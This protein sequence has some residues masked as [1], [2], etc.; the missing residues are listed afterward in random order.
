MMQ[1]V[2][3]GVIEPFCASVLRAPTPSAFF[4][5]IPSAFF[6]AIF[7]AVTRK[8]PHAPMSFIQMRPQSLPRIVCFV[9]YPW[10]ILEPLANYVSTTSHCRYDDDMIQPRT[11]R[12]QDIARHEPGHAQPQSELDLNI[13]TLV[14]D[15]RR[16]FQKGITRPLIW[17]RRQLAALS[18]MLIAEREPLEQALFADLHKSPTE[19]QITELG[20]LRSEISYTLRHLS[21]WAH[22][23]RTMAPLALQPA[24][25]WLVPEPL[26]VL[27]IIAPWNYPVQLLLSPLVGAIAAGNAAVIKPSELAPNVSTVLARIIP[28]YLD[29]RAIRIVEGAIPETTALLAQQF[30][31]IVY[32]GNGRVARIVMQAAAKHLTPVTLELGGKSPVWFDDDAHIDAAARRIAWAKF[33]NAGQTCVAPDYILTTPDRVERLTAALRRAST[34][35]W[36]ARPELSPDYGRIVNDRQFNRLT[37]YL[38]AP[39]AGTVATNS[40]TDTNTDADEGSRTVANT[41]T[42][43]SG[44]SQYTVVSGGTTDDGERYIEP[45][46]LAMPQPV[47]P[48]ATRTEANTPAV[49]LDEIFGPILPIVPV[50]DLEDAIAYVNAGDKPLALY[51]FSSS[52][53]TGQEFVA[54]TSSGAVGQGAGLIHVAAHTLPF[55]GVGASGMGAYHGAYSFQAFSHIKPV[56]RKPLHPDTLHFVQPPFANGLVRKAT[57]LLARL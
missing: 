43:S 20:V 27:L 9:R 51:V 4:P 21:R 30:D 32:T 35:L 54:R 8:Q 7:P 24:S 29:T 38:A 28:Q 22:P 41:G 1:A 2:T 26:G 15:V 14:E 33:T 57:Q 44:T 55:G 47:D 50:H 10:S 37:S 45:T 53:R 49:M 23:H 3:N 17:R 11:A 48:S 13:S 39:G 6:P 36:G 25:A 34:R 31:H 19:S 12:R 42:P 16:Q 56:L 52:R 5:A 46:I 40:N 18:Q